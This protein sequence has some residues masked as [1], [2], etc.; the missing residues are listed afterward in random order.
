MILAAAFLVGMNFT[1]LSVRHRSTMSTTRVSSAK[2]LNWSTMTRAHAPLQVLLPSIS[3]EMGC[4]I[5]TAAWVT[6]GLYPIVTLY[7][8]SSILTNIFG[9]SIS[10]ATMRPNLR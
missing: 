9:T 3:V 10:E 6:I 7:H 4:S 8:R 1:V 5:E 2:C